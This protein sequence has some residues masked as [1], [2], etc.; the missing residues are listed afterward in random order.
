M[1]EGGG[2]Q[3]AGEGVGQGAGAGRR[4]LVWDVSLFE[5][6]SNTYRKQALT[7][8]ATAVVLGKRGG[9]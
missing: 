1:K 9:K 6:D 3:S 7:V 8:L 5:P 4:E 2:T